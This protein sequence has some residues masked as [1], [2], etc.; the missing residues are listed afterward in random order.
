M[1]RQTH[2]IFTHPPAPPPPTPRIYAATFLFPILHRALLTPIP[3]ASIALARYTRDRTHSLDSRTHYSGWPSPRPVTKRA[4]APLR[5][6][7]GGVARELLHTSLGRRR[8]YP[9]SHSTCVAAAVTRY[10][11]VVHGARSLASSPYSLD[12]SLESLSCVVL[13]MHTPSAEWQ[14]CESAVLVVVRRVLALR[15]GLC[16]MC[17]VCARDES[18]QVGNGGVAVGADQCWSEKV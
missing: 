12:I 18:R 6:G 7:G 1:L 14:C 4:R 8:T 2:H 13:H 11:P 16:V 10:S 5:D 3:S 9:R 15:V 17:A